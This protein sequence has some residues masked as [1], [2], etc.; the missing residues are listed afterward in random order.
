MSLLPN[1]PQGDPQ[2][3]AANPAISAAV[4]ANAGSGKTKTLVDRVAR[5]RNA[6]AGKI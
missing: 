3:T 4:S 5:L 1:P 2:K 6:V